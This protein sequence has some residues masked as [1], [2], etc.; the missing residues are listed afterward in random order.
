MQPGGSPD[1]PKGKGFGKGKESAGIRSEG[2]HA[3]GCV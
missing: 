3:P 2:R 1:F